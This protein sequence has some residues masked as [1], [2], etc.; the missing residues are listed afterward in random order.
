MS[1]RKPSLATVPSKAKTNNPSIAPNA[2]S[3]YLVQRQAQQAQ[4]QSVAFAQIVSLLMQSPLYRHFSIADIEW[5]VLPPLATGMFTLAEVKAQA[6]GP[7][8]PAAV[9]LWANVSPEVDARLSTNLSAP[10]RLRPDEWRSGDQQWV[11]A[12]VGD[13]KVVNTVLKQLSN[14]TLK[15]RNVKVRAVVGD[16]KV[17]VKSLDE[18]FSPKAGASSS[19]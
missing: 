6:T 13:Q 15:G 12:A 11:I 8:V 3:E 9:V 5:L 17:I 2:S 10:I 7:S 19:I 14:S 1:S 16:G 18:V 4:R